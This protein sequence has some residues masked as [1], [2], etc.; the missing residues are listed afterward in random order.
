MTF[1]NLI[2]T[3]EIIITQFFLHDLKLS[4]LSNHAEYPK[5][6]VLYYVLLF[7]LHKEYKVK[8]I[9]SNAVYTRDSRGH[10]SGLYYLVL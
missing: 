6:Q 1:I 5:R 3:S 10:L 9:W 7:L 2:F 8:E 4:I